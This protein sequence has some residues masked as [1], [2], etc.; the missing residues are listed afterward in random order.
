M[1]NKSETKLRRWDVARALEQMHGMEK[2]VRLLI[3][4]LDRMLVDRDSFGIKKPPGI[5]GTAV[6]TT[7]Q[8][9]LFCEYSIKTYHSFLSK[10]GSCYSGH[11][12]SG[13]YD[14]ME[15]LFMEV[16]NRPSGDLGRRIISNIF[17]RE[18]CCPS[19][20]M[21]RPDCVQSIL[22]AGSANFDDWRY[23]YAER[24]DL[25]NGIPKGL[26]CVAKGLELLCRRSFLQRT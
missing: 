7:I 15:S 18:A 13:L 2:A 8:T 14:Q 10:D 20:W 21:S 11:S 22:M 26:F 23:G 3:A 25:T 9:A 12:L 6:V 1:N 4:E 5:V 17:S 24:G 16:E 19:E